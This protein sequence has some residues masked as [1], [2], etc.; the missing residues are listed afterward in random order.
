MDK[1]SIRQLFSE[2]RG[3]IS[4]YDKNLMDKVIYEKAMRLADK[5]HVFAIFHSFRS[6]V[7]THR[8]IESL[9]LMGKVVACPIIDKGNMHFIEIKNLDDLE[10]GHFGIMEPKLGRYMDPKD[11]DCIFIPMLAYNDDYY[12]IGYG[13]GYYDRFLS[14][15]TGIKIGLAYS[16]QYTDI[17][18]QDDNDIAFDILITEKG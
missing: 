14:Q 4:S 17:K 15:S 12:R 11:F 2:K 16:I 3:A 18:F 9:L 13:K 6:E 8:L 1:T 5:Y 7:D 10:P